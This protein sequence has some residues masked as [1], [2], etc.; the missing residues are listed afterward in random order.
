M[1]YLCILFCFTNYY[2]AKSLRMQ[3]NFIYLFYYE[4]LRENKE[5]ESQSTR[6]DTCFVPYSVTQKLHKK[7]KIIIILSMTLFLYKSIYVLYFCI[8]CSFYRTNF[9]LMGEE[10]KDFLFVDKKYIYGIIILN[11]K[12]MHGCDQ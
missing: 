5:E 2:R 11:L 1:K 7:R 12:K 9:F 3:F 8:F 4:F 6:R 10:K